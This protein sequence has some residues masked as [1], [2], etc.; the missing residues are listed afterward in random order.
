MQNAKLPRDPSDQDGYFEG[1]MQ[2][3]GNE[4][5]SERLETRSRRQRVQ[6]AC[7]ECYRRKQKCNRK[8][9]CQHCVARRIPERCRTAQ[10]QDDHT[11]LALRLTRLEQ[12]IQSHLYQTSH[13]MDLLFQQISQ[14]GAVISSKSDQINKRSS[15][16]EKMV[17][18][19]GATSSPSNSDTDAMS[20]NEDEQSTQETIP[21]MLQAAGTLATESKVDV[22]PSQCP[23]DARDDLDLFSVSQI[24]LQSLTQAMLPKQVIR[25]LIEVFLD[26]IN[27]YRHPIPKDMVYTAFDSFYESGGTVSLHNITQCGLLATLSSFGALYV[28]VAH[29]EYVQELS[30][31]GKFDE[32]ESCKQFGKAAL[33]ACSIAQDTDRE[34]IYTVITYAHLSRLFFVRGRI[35]LSWN[36][37]ANCVRVALSLRLHRDGKKLGLTPETTHLRR[38]VWSLVYS[39]ERTTSLAYDRPLLISDAVCDTRAPSFDGG[40][41]QVPEPLRA[42]FFDTPAPN[43][44]R[45]NDLRSKLASHIG[46]LV[47]E[48]QNV[49]KT[50]NYSRILRIHHDFQRFVQ[51]KLPFYFQMRFEGSHLVQNTQC[52][53]HYAYIRFQRYQLWLDINF[54]VLALHCPFF[55]RYHCDKRPKYVT[56]YKACLEA[57]K[58]NF[59]LRREMLHDD[60]LPRRYRDSMVGF[61][62]FNTVVVAGFLLLKQPSAEDA[63]WLIESMN[64][65][66]AWRHRLQL[67]LQ[68]SSEGDKESEI[69]RAFLDRANLN[70][71]DISSVSSFGSSPKERS[72]KRVRR[73]ESNLES[74]PSLESFPKRTQG[75]EMLTEVRNTQN[76]QQVPQAAQHPNPCETQHEIPASFLSPNNAFNY[77]TMPLQSWT[78]NDDGSKLNWLLN[79]PLI[80]PN[81]ALDPQTLMP[82][83]PPAMA[84]EENSQAFAFPTNTG[85]ELFDTQQK[86]NLW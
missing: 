29:P 2:S 78:A 51:E 4:S 32:L 73:P 6:F 70:D 8:T 77:D 52:D 48:V 16:R 71:T 69:V 46:E 62:W 76:W 80:T 40:I 47:F 38:I 44:L 15:S 68:Y 86:L 60:T 30:Q 25:R 83:W 85:D 58:L 22:A 28:S 3:G 56:S 50:V 53:A 21:V 10:Q 54:F 74:A 5:Q 27:L 67:S 35:S 59:A 1:T 39:I 19:T 34:D 45:I 43:L 64:E 82:V 41:E 66:L 61:R 20:G 7:T 11:D 17:H 13:Q 12:A 14:P 63:A 79:I 57:V 23:R 65:F 81:I 75:N 42:L 72:A 37:L 33:A 18:Q 31:N 49:H 9:P 55:L 26:T 84:N 24:T 36:N